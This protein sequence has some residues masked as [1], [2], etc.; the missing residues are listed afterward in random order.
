MSWHYPDVLLAQEVEERKREEVTT[1][2]IKVRD[3]AVVSPVEAVSKMNWDYDVQGDAH[4][5]PL[6]VF[7]DGRFTMLRMADVSEMPALFLLAEKDGEALLGNYVVRG[8][9]LV[10][11]RLAPHGILLKIGDKEVK[12]LPKAR[13][14]GNGFWSNLF[15]NTD[16]R[17]R[18]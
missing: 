17:V 2:D 11:Q 10:L 3:A 13:N 12:V 1:A 14:Q 8:N 7:D 18:Q 4:F 15:G 6:Q 5:R 9:Y 16:K